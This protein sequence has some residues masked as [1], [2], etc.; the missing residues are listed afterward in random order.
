MAIKKTVCAS[1]R[2]TGRDIILKYNAYVIRG[3]VEEK[4]ENE[5]KEVTMLI[6]CKLLSLP[7]RYRSCNQE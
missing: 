2:K 4:K 1:N 6:A 3:V 7:S 5:Y